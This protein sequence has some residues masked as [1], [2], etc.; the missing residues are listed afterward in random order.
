MQEKKKRN[1]IY[2]PNR[3][4]EIGSKYG[5]LTVITEHSKTRNGGL[6]YTCRCDCGNE[7]NVLIDHLR[8]GNT[9]S[10]GCER[11]KKG[12]RHHQWDGI[13]DI[14]GNYWFTR[15][16]SSAKN[17]KR[18]EIELSITKE[19]AWDLF[20]QQDRKC[21]LSGLPLHFPNKWRSKDWTASLDRIDSSIGYVEGNVQWVHKDINIMKNKFDQNYFL[22]MCSYIAD[23]SR[24][25]V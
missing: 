20:L 25:G 15:I 9:K 3:R 7:C 19:Y 4:N 1:R 13:G 24:S 22:R 11:F 12:E 10:C 17:K 21:A 2:V 18:G 5:K 14:S 16:V 6:R 23:Q 8:R